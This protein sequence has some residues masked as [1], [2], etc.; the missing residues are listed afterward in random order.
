MVFIIC[1]ISRWLRNKFPFLW[2]Q[3]TIFPWL[4]RRLIKLR[5]NSRLSKNKRS[6]RLNFKLSALRVP[7]IIILNKWQS[8]GRLSI[9]L[10]RYLRS[11]EELNWTLLFLSLNRCL[12]VNTDRILSWFM[13]YRTKAVRNAVWDMIWLCLSLVLWLIIPISKR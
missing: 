2:R 8:E 7:E 3:S 13:T 11:T 9:Q 6:T 5:K 10:L 1:W 12:Q 4:Q